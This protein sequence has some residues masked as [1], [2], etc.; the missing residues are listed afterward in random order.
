MQTNMAFQ[1]AT[2][3]YGVL[4]GILAAPWRRGW[5]RSYTCVMLRSFRPMRPCRL[6]PGTP[7][8]VFSVFADVAVTLRTMRELLVM[9]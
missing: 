4:D 2:Q 8:D 3:L 1:V 6:T 9:P 7:W 5:Q